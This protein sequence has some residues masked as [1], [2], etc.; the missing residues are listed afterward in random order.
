[1]VEN[2]RFIK[3]Q[4]SATNPERHELTDI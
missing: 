4:Y 2:G 3:E 1:M